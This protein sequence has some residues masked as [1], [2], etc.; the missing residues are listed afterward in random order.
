MNALEVQYYTA[1]QPRDEVCQVKEFFVARLLLRTWAAGIFTVDGWEIVIQEQL[2]PASRHVQQ[3]IGRYYVR[4][5]RSGKY[6][7]GE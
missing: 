3:C 1:D 2:L 4:N 6:W 7:Q 5:T